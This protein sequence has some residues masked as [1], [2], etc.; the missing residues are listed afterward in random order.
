M[1][2]NVSVH[3]QKAAPSSLQ[4]LLF[5]YFSY[6]DSS[7]EMKTKVV[8]ETFCVKLSKNTFSWLDKTFHSNTKKTKRK[9][10]ATVNKTDGSNC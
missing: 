10:T 4:K 7:G 1:C 8:N 3:Q 6:S 2:P 9:K 5:I